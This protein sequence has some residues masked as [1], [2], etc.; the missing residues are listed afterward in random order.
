M[1]AVAIWHATYNITS[2][3]DGAIAA[4]ATACVIVW[5]MRLLARTKRRARAP[6]DVG[7]QAERLRAGLEK[8]RQFAA[9]DPWSGRKHPTRPERTTPT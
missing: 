1:L 6:A 4:I 8:V 3:S 2:A 5:G 9:A 7:D